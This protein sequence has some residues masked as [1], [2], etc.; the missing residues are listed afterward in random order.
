MAMVGAL[1]GCAQQTDAE[2]ARKGLASAPPPDRS[3]Q[4]KGL[5]AYLAARDAEI[6]GDMVAAATYYPIAL[7]SDPDNVSLLRRATFFAAVEGDIA[8]ASQWAQRLLTR[9]PGANLAPLIVAADLVAHGQA[10]AAAER[11]GRLNR[12]GLNSFL[13]PVMLAWA[14]HGA[15]NAAGALA[16]LD[17]LDSTPA[18]R[19]L[20]ALHGALIQEALGNTAAARTAYEHYLTGNDRPSLRGV[21]LA[22]G[23]LVRQGLTDRAK[24]LADDYAK[25]FPDSLLL[26][27][28]LRDFTGGRPVA[29]VKTAAEGMAE[30]FYGTASLLADNDATSAALFNRLAL[31]LRP[32]YALSQLLMGQLLAGQ[33]RQDDAIAAFRKVSGEPGLDLAAGLAEAESLRAAKRVDDAVTALE[34]LATAHPK[35]ADPLIDLGD[36]LRQ[37]ERFPEAATAYSRA[38]E[39]L[40][41]PQERHWAVFL[42]AA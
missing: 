22:G 37:A 41:P 2:P 1:A 30:L 31:H 42:D 18:Y 10:K 33:G 28:T 25:R 4:P 29:P 17:E 14:R 21:Q 12:Q 38:I 5:G 34:R 7:A 19:P 11:L 3:W 8:N 39:R 9:E 16:A 6:H 27:N 32:T 26:E 24:A 23:F 35:R 36:M 15:G 13:V 20:K 40:G